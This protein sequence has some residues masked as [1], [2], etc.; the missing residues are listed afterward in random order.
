MNYNDKLNVSRGTVYEDYIKE[1]LKWN[2]KINLIAKGTE[3]V[4]LD[5]HINDSEQLVEILSDRNSRIVDLGSG[6]G[7]PGLI[8][9]LNGFRRVALVESNKK[10]AA[11]LHSLVKKFS[12]E[13]EIF[14]CRVEA[15]SGLGEVDFITARAFASIRKVIEYSLNLMNNRTKIVLLKGETWQDEL[16]EAEEDYIFSSRY[17]D[18]RSHFGSKIIEIWDICKKTK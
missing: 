11:F 3:D 17:I 18:S 4:I 14:N 7:F 12:L 1:L 9:A 15:L 8:L 13:V 5:R 2:S 6:G 16:K 10:K